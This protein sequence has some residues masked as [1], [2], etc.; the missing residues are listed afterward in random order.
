VQ[1][2][3][4]PIKNLTSLFPLIFLSKHISVYALGRLK[5]ILDIIW[6]LNQHFNLKNQRNL[7]KQVWMLSFLIGIICILLHWW[8]KVTLHI[9]VRI[10][11][12][13]HKILQNIHQLFFWQLICQIIFGDLAKFCG[14]LRM[15]E[16]YKIIVD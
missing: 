9:K 7:K 10:F 14:R 4:I 13:G 11:W 3:I 6:P 2:P 16:I 1:W 5:W 15:Y 8:K 12:E